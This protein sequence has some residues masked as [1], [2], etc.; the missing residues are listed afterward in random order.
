MKRPLCLIC[1]LFLVTFVFITQYSKTAATEVAVAGAGLFIGTLE[2]KQVT[3]ERTVLWLSNVTTYDSYTSYDA[4]LAQHNQATQSPIE[5]YSV[6]I[7]CTGMEAEEVPKMGA[8]VLVSGTARTFSHATNYGEF[9]Q[10]SYQQNLGYDFYVTSGILVA[11]SNSYHRYYEALYIIKQNLSSRFQLY[12]PEKEASI[13]KAMLLGEKQDLDEGISYLYQKNGIIHIL[14]I[15]GLHISM[16]GMFLYQAGKKC[17]ITLPIISCVTIICLTQYV[18]MTGATASGIRAVSMFAIYL[19]ALYNRRSYD[20]VTAM[21]LAYVLL[22]LQNPYAMYQVGCQLSFGAILAIGLLNPAICRLIPLPEEEKRSVKALFYQAFLV[23]FSVQIM[24]LPILITCYYEYP[25]TS[26]VLNL[27]IVPTVGIV[28]AL[29]IGLLGFSFFSSMLAQCVAI[30]IEI[31][32]QCYEMICEFMLAIPFQLLPIAMITPLEI[33]CY[34]VVIAGV[35]Y[36]NK[37]TPTV[38]IAKG[39]ILCIAIGMLLYSP[40][41]NLRITMIDVGQGDGILIETPSNQAYLLDGGSTTKTDVGN[42]QIIPTLKYYGIRKLDGVFITHMDSDHYSGICEILEVQSTTGEIEIEAMYLTKNVTTDKASELYELIAL[43]EIPI[44]YLDTSMELRDGE[45][46]FQVLMPYDG[47]VPATE[48]E[49]SLVM[50]ITYGDFDILCTGDMEAEGEEKLIDS[51]LALEG[52]QVDYEILKVGHHGSNNATSEQ[53]LEVIQGEVALIS[54]GLNNVYGHPHEDVSARLEE[55][56]M[57]V[58]ET[59]KVGAIVIESN[60]KDYWIETFLETNL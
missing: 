37:W 21:S 12:L 50:R 8:T 19:F 28:V 33:I 36:W 54:C 10:A 55:A 16:I 18:V 23:S 22:L 15:S 38:R 26:I 31:I 60:G 46:N 56:G 17:G 20:I 1:F 14:A 13:M 52:G 43:C 44:Y 5:T 9:D 34:Y 41:S 2:E 27:L 24:T 49:N 42:Y 3:E 53:L 4:A 30:L 25:I 6:I 35:I 11:T 29:G 57:E 7:Y 40:N 45:V 59:P 47:Y 48:N 51:I 32:L 58:Y 39:A